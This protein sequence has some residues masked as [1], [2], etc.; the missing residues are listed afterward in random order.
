VIAAEI[1]SEP[2]PRLW[3]D[4]GTGN[5]LFTHW[6]EKGTAEKPPFLLVQGREDVA[7]PARYSQCY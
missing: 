5:S 2:F 3:R 6:C 4:K 1:G 7:C